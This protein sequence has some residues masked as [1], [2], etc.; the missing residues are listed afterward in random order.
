MQV[1]TFYLAF[2]KSIVCSIPIVRL[3]RV[4]GYYINMGK[5]V[6]EVTIESV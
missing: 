4:K 3:L 2:V 1:I 5:A 6:V